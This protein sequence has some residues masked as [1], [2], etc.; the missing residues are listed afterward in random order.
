MLEEI[1]INKVLFAKCEEELQKSKYIEA[2][3]LLYTDPPYGM[4]Y[5]SN[6]P[7]DDTWCKKESSENRFSKPIL[8]DKPRDINW[9]NLANL[10]YKVLKKDTFFFLHCNL[11][12]IYNH[13]Q[14]FINAGFKVKGAIAW[15]KRFAIGGD[16]KASMKRDWEP[17][18]YFTKG[19]PAWQSVMVPRKGKEKEIKRLSEIAD[20]EFDTVEA[21]N[22]NQWV[23]SLPKKEKVGF[24]TQ[25]PIALC[26]QIIKVA[27]T[28]GQL[29][30]DPFCGSGA[31]SKA[32]VA[33]G[34]NFLTIEADQDVFDRHQ[35]L[36]ETKQSA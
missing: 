6:I 30:L 29:V 31:I 18:M 9:H 14:A 3:D 22:M 4:N 2:F 7:G 36:I 20:W 8:N 28:P 21:E 15:N 16:L 5:L 24:P 11:E 26:S 32:A 33:T 17:I 27:T 23:F 10:F 12:M 19:R 35:T 25:K 1:M 34:R 13:T